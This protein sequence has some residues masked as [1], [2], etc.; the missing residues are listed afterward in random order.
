MVS[1]P[2]YQPNG[3]RPVRLRFP[4]FPDLAHQRRTRLEGH[5]PR[6][7]A[8]RGNFAGGAHVLERLDLPQQFFGVPADLRGQHFHRTDHKVGIE[9][10]GSRGP[11]CVVNS[12]Y[13]L[14]TVRNLEPARYEL[15]E[16]I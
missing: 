7:P 5:L 11:F 16:G 4:D 15:S 9:V 12:T 14:L 10:V 6:L 3:R 1:L 8:G 2:N 13:R